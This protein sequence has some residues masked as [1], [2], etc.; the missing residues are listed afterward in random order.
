MV[1]RSGTKSFCTLSAEDEQ[2]TDREQG[3]DFSDRW[4]TGRVVALVAVTL[5]AVALAGV[6]LFGGASSYTITARFI[7]AGQLVKGNPVH[8][9]GVPIGSVAG[10]EITRDGQA[11]VELRIEDDHAPLRAGT[12]ARIRQL[13]LSGIANR[14]VEL[15]LPPAG[16]AEIADGGRIGTDHTT[17]AVD[18]DELFNTLDPKTRKALQG[19]FKGSANQFRG[20]GEQARAGLRYLNPALA[21]SSRLFGELTRDQPVLER[22]LVDSSRL[23]TALADRRDDLAA[24]IGNLN[25]TTRALGSEKAALAESIERLP[26]FMRRANTT[27][28][29]LR[30]TLDDVD[31]LVDASKPVARELGPFLEQARGFARDARP[32]IRDLSRTVRRRGRDNDLVE[33]MRSVPPLADIALDRKERFLS[34]G[35]R[36]VSVG[37]VDGAFPETVRALARGT[38]EIGLGRAY[39]MDFLGWF[40]DFSTTGPGF[41][42][43]GA[44]A[45]FHASFAE[46]LPEPSPGPVRQ[47]QYRRCPGAAEARASDGSNVLSAEEME[48]LQCEES[49]RATGDVE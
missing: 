48:E 41:D 27:F 2:P 8:T 6:V 28:V 18:L 40:D 3:E 39:A 1:L 13:S 25:D 22:F 5:A 23:V 11:E 45:R 43:L 26:P 35:G 46:H 33:L 9:G 47:G 21:T 17:T 44:V 29:N 49:A 20:R 4:S 38:P 16:R 19:F 24:L 36:R 7:N 32:T 37:E 15:T 30:A 14:Y 42:A 34:P 10:I 31:P 12:R